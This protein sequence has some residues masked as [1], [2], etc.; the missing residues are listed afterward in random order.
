MA[1]ENGTLELELEE[2]FM[3]PIHDA[4]PKPPE[5]STS[6]EPFRLEDSRFDSIDEIME[7]VEDNHHQESLL[8]IDSEFGGD[9][10]VEES[11]M[12][13]FHD[14]IPKPTEVTTSIERIRL[15]HFDL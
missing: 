15:E 13:T 14:S 3:S 2:S 11:F 9:G 4:I 8:E 12:S 10:E 6:I 1:E 5:A 7:E